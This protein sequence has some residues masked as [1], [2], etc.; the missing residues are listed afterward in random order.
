MKIIT[1]KMPFIIKVVSIE[2][3]SF[4]PLQEY[5]Q[6]RTDVDNLIWEKN[7]LSESL[8]SSV[9]RYSVDDAHFDEE[10]PSPLQVCF[11]LLSIHY[12][13]SRKVNHRHTS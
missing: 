8:S 10:Q 3:F 11:M 12:C 7:K 6:Y 9:E 2:N 1:P 5:N 4:F 13:F